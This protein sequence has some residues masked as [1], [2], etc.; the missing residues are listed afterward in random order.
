[1]RPLEEA[2]ELA[3]EASEA[4]VEVRARGVTMAITGPSV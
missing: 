4:A 3:S 2:D 1:M